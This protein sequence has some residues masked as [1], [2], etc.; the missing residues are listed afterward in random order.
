MN[1][2][3]HIEQLILEGIELPHGE[4]ALL[5][6]TVETELARLLATDGLTPGLLASGAVPSLPA[7]EMQIGTE[8]N[9]TRLGEQIARS[10]YGVIGP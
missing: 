4:R 7:G 9:P 6:A 8:R 3:V 2:S 10:V 5:Q 1:I